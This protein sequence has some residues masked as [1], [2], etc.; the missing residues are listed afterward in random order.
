MSR[1]ESRSIMTG[2][3]KIWRIQAQRVINEGLGKGRVN[4]ERDYT[5]CR[6][7]IRRMMSA[8]CLR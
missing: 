4:E 8:D 5:L 2:G 3:G 1:M 7:M 6:R